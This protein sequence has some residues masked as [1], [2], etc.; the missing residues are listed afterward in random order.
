MTHDYDVLMNLPIHHFYTMQNRIIEIQRKARI[1]REDMVEW[2]F[3]NRNPLESDSFTIPK[4]IQ[5]EAD[6]EYICEE[7]TNIEKERKEKVSDESI[8]RD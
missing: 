6:L 1:L 2:G 5:L 8:C 3:D 7:M 4:L